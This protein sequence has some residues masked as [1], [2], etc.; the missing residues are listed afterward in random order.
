MRCAKKKKTRENLVN[1][2]LS[3]WL[4][5]SSVKIDDFGKLVKHAVT[6]TS[7]NDGI[8]KESADFMWG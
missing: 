1:V 6:G 7:D 3:V 5:E 8:A 2:L 4:Q